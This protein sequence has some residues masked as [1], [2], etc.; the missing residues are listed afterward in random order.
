[1]IRKSVILLFLLLSPIASSK[2]IKLS[3]VEANYVL[4][5]K[6]I[7]AGVMKL[8]LKKNENQILLSTVYDGNLL[9]AIANKGFREEISEI[10]VDNNKLIPKKYIYK[11]NKDFYKVFINKNSAII[12]QNNIDTK[13]TSKNDIYDP[14]TMI[15]LLMEDYPNINENYNVLTKKNLKSYHYEYKDNQEIIIKEKKYNGYSAQYE[16][17]EKVN[18]LFFSLEHKNLM[19]Y[20]SIFK[21]GEE[22]I[23]IEISEIKILR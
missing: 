6:N 20:S 23:R 2:D 11:D 16:S 9:A 14:L 13:I 5:Y 18:F 19:V 22:K 15:L 4:Y 1:M 7:E 3:E 12:N 17:G 21:N 8:K 10:I